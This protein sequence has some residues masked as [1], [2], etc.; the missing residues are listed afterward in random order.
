MLYPKG[1]NA[2]LMFIWM[3]G[4]VTVAT[5]ESYRTAFIML[6]LSG[7]VSMLGKD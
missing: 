1:T 6:M 4:A 5:F 3:A 2:K 7:I